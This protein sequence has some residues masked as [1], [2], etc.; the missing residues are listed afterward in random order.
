M[1]DLP[2]GFAKRT[3]K[4]TRLRPSEFD[5]TKRPIRNSGAFFGYSAIPAKLS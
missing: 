3:T 5:F 2:R 4:I 1:G